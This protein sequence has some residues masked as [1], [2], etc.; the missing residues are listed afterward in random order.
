MVFAQS[1]D[2]VLLSNEKEIPAFHLRTS[3]RTIGCTL[4]D[5]YEWADKNC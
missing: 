4:E 5:V 2:A 3:C 1:A